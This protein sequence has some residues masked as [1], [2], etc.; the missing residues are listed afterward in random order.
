MS[1]SAYLAGFDERSGRLPGGLGGDCCRDLVSSENSTSFGTLVP[2][3]IIKAQGCPGLLAGG[4]K[5]NLPWA[6]K[7]KRSLRLSIERLVS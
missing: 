1:I 6:K 5:F 2:F 7:S 4:S 3:K